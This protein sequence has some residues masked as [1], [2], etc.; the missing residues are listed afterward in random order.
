MVC[1]RA[2]DTAFTEVPQLVLDEVDLANQPAENLGRMIDPAQLAYVIFTSG[3]TGK[4]KGA[5]VEHRG[6]FNHLLAKV[7][8]FAIDEDTILA[9]N[10]SIS[11]DISIWQGLAAL[12][13]GGQTIVYPQQC[14]LEASQWLQQLQTD[15]VNLLEVVPSYL[16]E[17]LLLETG[18]NLRHLDGLQY[19]VATGETLKKNLVERWFAR[20][21]D[22]P[23]G[24]VYG[25]T[26]AS[27]DITHAIFHTPPATPNVSIGQP[28]RNLR[29]Y[30][31]DQSDQLCPVGIKGEICVAGVGVGRGYLRDPEKTAAVFA[32]DPFGAPGVRL[33]RTGDLGRYRADGHLEFFG[34]KDHQVK[35]RGYRIELGEIEEQ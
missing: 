9:Q 33:Y 1:D 24:N 34:R 27:D 14:V 19:L 35:I 6:L 32:T 2:P 20:Y 3:T 21:P 7:E 17:L 25:P 22:I 15:R 8:D 12:L 5:T 23:L 10:A 16:N 13:Y 31:L 4:P 29:V 26:E 18:G 30:V 11:F 28:L